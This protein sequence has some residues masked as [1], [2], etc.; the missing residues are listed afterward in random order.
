MLKELEIKVEAVYVGDLPDSLVK[1]STDQI[2]VNLEGVVGDKH[3]GFTKKA[4]SRD[5]E[6]YGNKIVRGQV[7]RNWRQW[8]GLE[9]SEMARVAKNLG[10][11]SFDPALLGPNVLFSGMENFTQLPKG[12][13]IWFPQDAAFYIEGENLPCIGPGEQI[14]KQYPE[15]KPSAF[16][17][18]AMGLR[19]LVG[20]IYRPGII[21]PGDLAIVHLYQPRSY[22]IP[23][24]ESKS[25]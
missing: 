22:S 8:S 4:D 18:A 20:T 9:S 5:R 2:E 17:K 7:V 1:T 11:E 12:S 10:I 15:V 14:A 13:T 24:T 23:Y 25:S 16:V 21:K 3:G 6:L 19:G